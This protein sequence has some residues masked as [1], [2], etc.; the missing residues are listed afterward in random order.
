MKTQVVHK[1]C[2]SSSERI[3]Q[4]CVT[5]LENYVNL[6]CYEGNWHKD[7]HR[8]SYAILAWSGTGAPISW[9]GYKGSLC[10]LYYDSIYSCY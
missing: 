8:T 9:K 4:N 1:I 7:A 10:L 6:L 3:L 5:K 2:N